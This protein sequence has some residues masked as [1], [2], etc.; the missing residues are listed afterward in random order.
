LAGVGKFPCAFLTQK[1]RDSESGLDYFLARYY[2][3]AQGRFTS[4]DAFGGSLLNPQTLN[5]YS[6]VQGNPLRYVDPF[7]HFAEDP[8]DKGGRPRG[9]R[10][11][12]R[13]DLRHPF[14][15]LK[16]DSNFKPVKTPEVP[17]GVAYE[18]PGGPPIHLKAK[19]PGGFFSRLGGKIAG[20]FRWFGRALGLVHVASQLAD[21]SDY[22]GGH[23]GTV[24]GSLA[25]LPP[26]RIL[27]TFLNGEVKVEELGRDEIFFRVFSLPQFMRGSYL[28][29][30]EYTSSFGAIRE[31]ALDPALTPNQATQIVT[32]VVPGGTVV[33]RGRAAPQGSLSGG[34]SQIY[35]P[36]AAGNP[37]IQWKNQRPIGQ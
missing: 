29:S 8:D 31:L 20:G 36:G 34:G 22:P 16:Q 37:A 3:S 1:E 14:K 11:P 28:T 21:P 7:G 30:T 33:Y 15:G 32:V 23:H 12:S 18:S 25:D 5:L 13:D 2:S 6:Y 19:P 35:V 27:D 4:A 17:G 24:G 26:Q 9:A 10:D